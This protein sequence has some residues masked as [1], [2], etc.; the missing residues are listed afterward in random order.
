MQLANYLTQKHNRRIFPSNVEQTGLKECEKGR[1]DLGICRYTLHMYSTYTLEARS[2]VYAPG[3]GCSRSCT[4]YLPCCPGNEPPDA[5]VQA[6]A[7]IL[8]YLMRIPILTGRYRESEGKQWLGKWVV[9]EMSFHLQNT[10]KRRFCDVRDGK[11]CED[12][13]RRHRYFCIHVL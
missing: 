5:D 2:G 1:Q 7:C 12:G 13:I 9:F 4:G 11:L 8:G 10:C 6:M 3:G